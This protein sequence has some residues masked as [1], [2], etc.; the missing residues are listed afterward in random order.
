MPPTCQQVQAPVPGLHM[1]FSS[2]STVRNRAEEHQ[3]CC[4]QVQPEEQCTLPCGTLALCSW[5]L[6][7]CQ[8]LLCSTA[9]DPGQR[10]MVPAKALVLPQCL[11]SLLFLGSDLFFWSADSGAAG[12][13]VI[14]LGSCDS[15]HL[16]RTSS[17][18]LSLKCYA[19]TPGLHAA[20]IHNVLS[21][22]GQPPSFALLPASL[23]AAHPRKTETPVVSLAEP[24]PAS[25]QMLA[26]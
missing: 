9:Q 23:R 12:W 8:A 20:C 15:L 13:A 25:S 1:L 6:T 18:L 10:T 11:R 22:E 14:L 17:D 26:A 5:N 7:W 19:A 16:A 3:A 2:S 4:C 24:K 21:T